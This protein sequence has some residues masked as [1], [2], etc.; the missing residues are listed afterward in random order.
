MYS[1]QHVEFWN[2]LAVLTPKMVDVFTSKASNESRWVRNF[3][4]SRVCIE[5][6]IS[7]IHESPGMTELQAKTVCVQFLLASSQIVPGSETR[8]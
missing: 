6:F 7:N 1:S 3:N 8:I 2:F 4:S 5:L